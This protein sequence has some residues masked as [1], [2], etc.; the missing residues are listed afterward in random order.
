MRVVYAKTQSDCYNIVKY[1]LYN[2]CYNIVKYLLYNI[3]VKLLFILRAFKYYIINKFYK[4]IENKCDRLM[5]YIIKVTITITDTI[6]KYLVYLKK[7][8]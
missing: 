6:K 5:F 4:I 7:K 1:L 3:I 8:T 2:I